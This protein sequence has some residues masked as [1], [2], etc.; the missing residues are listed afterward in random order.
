[1]H[2]S[3]IYDY[4]ESF[5]CEWVRFRSVGTSGIMNRFSSGKAR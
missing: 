3:K 5:L 4:A 1:M 2:I